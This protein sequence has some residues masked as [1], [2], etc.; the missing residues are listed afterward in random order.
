MFGPNWPTSGEVDIIEGVNSQTKNS[1]AL[2]TSPGCSF[3]KQTQTGVFIN[4]NCDTKLNDNSGCSNKATNVNSYGTGF[5]KAGGGIY[6]TQWTKDFIKIWHF[7]RTSAFPADIT[8]GKPNPAKWGTPLAY[9]K[10]SSK[11]NIDSHFKSMNLV[12]N[13]NFCGDWAG[14]VWSA[15]STCR[16]KAADCKTYVAKNPTAYN[17]A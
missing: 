12:L 6:A 3:T 17:S 13:I 14:N 1:M 5:N 8:S 10:A 7:A 11:C 16:A 4:S 9:W 2:H 15:D